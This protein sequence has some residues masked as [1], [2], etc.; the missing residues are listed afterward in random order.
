[1][2]REARD[3]KRTATRSGEHNQQVH[4]PMQRDVVVSGWYVVNVLGAF[5]RGGGVLV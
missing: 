5:C 1:M 4:P 2:G 3:V